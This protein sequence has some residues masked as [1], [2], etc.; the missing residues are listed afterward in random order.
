MNNPAIAA[1]DL[2]DN[3]AFLLYS[4]GSF[5]T[6]T[7]YLNVNLMAQRC[8]DAEMQTSKVHT[9]YQRVQATLARFL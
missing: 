2:S 6:R 8:R 7:N 5:R 4:C 9:R 3:R 1:M